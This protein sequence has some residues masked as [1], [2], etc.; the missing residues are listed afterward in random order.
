MNNAVMFL[1]AITPIIWLIISLSKMKMA[2]YLACPIALAISAVLAVTAF[3]MTPLNMF[4]AGLEGVALAV[5]P[6]ILVIIAAVFT[7]NLSIYT[8]NMELIKQMLTG[9]TSDKRILVLI[10]A[11]GFGG[12]LE[13]MAGFGTAVAIPASMLYALGFDP[14]LAAGVC[15]ISNAT[16]TA[17]GSIGIPTVTLSQV[18]GLNPEALSFVTVIQLIIPILITPFVIVAMA[19]KSIKALKGVGFITFISGISF[20]IPELIAAKFIGA[21]LPVIVGSVCSMLCTIAFAKIQ[22]KKKQNNDYIISSD[23]DKEKNKEKIGTKRA[24]IAWLPF[25]L[26]F[27]FLILTSNLIAPLHNTLSAVKTSVKIYTGE[28]A[29]LYTF[30]WVNTPGVLILL[31]A[32]IGGFVQKAGFTDMIKVLGCTVKQMCG[33]MITIIS[34]IA[35]AKIMGYSGMINIIA[36]MAVAATGSVYPLIAPAIGSLGTFIT[37]SATSSSVLFG[38]LQA[39]AASAINA[40][41]YWIAAANTC[42]ATA[43]KIISPQSISIAV[44]ATKMSGK[45]GEILSSTVKYFIM[46]IVLM[47]LITLFGALLF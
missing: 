22:G 9:V 44:A 23:S 16:P 40:N 27:V 10:I 4:T 42:G 20:A 3:K 34:V 28:N 32:F 2:G 31:A 21:E 45:E 37:G 5:W 15:L 29:P 7:Y 18:S 35:T 1:L 33:T 36:A 19:G 38:K 13:G 12:F 26:I 25:I 41:P 11:W 46:F 17:F 24:V 43:G 39:E 6:I 47:G 30:V 8:G 14:L